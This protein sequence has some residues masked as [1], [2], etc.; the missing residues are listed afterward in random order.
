M[1][2]FTIFPRK[3]NNANI[4]NSFKINKNSISGS[5]SNSDTKTCQ[6]LDKNKIQKSVSFMNMDTNVLNKVLVIKSNNI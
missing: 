2:A 4:T 6:R 5:Q 3:K 1:H